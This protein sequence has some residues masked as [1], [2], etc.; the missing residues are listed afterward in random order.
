MRYTYPRAMLGRAVGLSGII[1]FSSAAAG[2]SIASG[3]LA[4]T[5]WHWLFAINIPFGLLAL[6]LSEKTLAPATGT[7]HKWD[8]RSAILNAITVILLITGIDG[9]GEPNY[10]WIAAGRMLARRSSSARYW[11]AGSFRSEFR[12]LRSTSSSDRF[13][14]SRRSRSVCAFMA[15]GLAFVALP[16]YFVDALGISQV[17]AGLL[18]TPWPI[19]AGVMSHFS[20]RL[21]DR[22]SLR[23]LGTSGMLVMCTGMMLLALA[24]AHPSTFDIVW[25]AALG[26]RRV[27]VL[28]RAE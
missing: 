9:I 5:S 11:F 17:K 20:G 19:A 4:I 22:H 25:R 8:L 27:W 24:P 28:R 13:S 16:F 26:G 23:V 3:I 7:R 18:L 1:V 6:S 14:P 12:C 21:A 10:R 15:Q 2:P